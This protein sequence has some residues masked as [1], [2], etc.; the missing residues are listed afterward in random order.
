MNCCDFEPEV[1]FECVTEIIK[2]LRSG[3]MSRDTTLEI[4]QHAACFIGSGAALLQGNDEDS[5]GPVYVFRGTVNGAADEL[6]ALLA[7]YNPYEGGRM[8]GVPWLAVIRIL[9][10]ILL[11]LLKDEK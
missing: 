5:L 1:K 11:D 6:E 8:N 4:A 9:L 2:L 10:P 7:P 3:D